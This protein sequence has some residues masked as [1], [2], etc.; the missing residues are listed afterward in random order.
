MSDALGEGQR[1]GAACQ[2]LFR[3]SEEPLDQS[4][5]P[6]GACPRIVPAIDK[7]MVAVVLQMIQFAPRIGVFSS[8]RELADH[9]RR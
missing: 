2:R 6:S 7:P 1:F 4:A 5:N 8:H 9:D 3:I